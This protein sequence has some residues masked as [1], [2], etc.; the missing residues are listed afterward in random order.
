[1][2]GVLFRNFSYITLSQAANY[3]IPLITIPYISRVVGVEKF[4]W[5]EFSYSVVLYF[6]QLVE[7]SFDITA[8]RRMAVISHNPILVSRLFSTVF[9]SKM[10]LWALSTVI[11][12][13]LLATNT[14][15]RA[16]AWPLLGYYF[17]TFSF[18][19]SQNWFFQGLQKL[20]VVALANV[21]LKL[22]FAILLFL[23]VKAESDY[24]L[25]AVSTTVGYLLV[26]MVTFWYA[27]RLIPELRVYFPGFK[28][29]IRNIKNGFYIFSAGMAN[30]F[31]A[32]SGMYWAGTL[33]GTAQ[34]GHFSAAHKLYM[35][36]QSMM[37]Y[38][39][40]MTLL[41]HLS[42]KMMEGF[43]VY[44]KTFFRYLKWILLSTSLVS[45]LLYLMS[46][47]V[48][49]VLFGKDFLHAHTLFDLFIPSLI[50][51]VF[52]NLIVYQ[53]FIHLKRDDLHFKVLVVLM[54]ISIT[55]NYIAI[56]HFGAIGGAGFRSIMDM[57]YVLL[58]WWWL[59][60]AFKQYLTKA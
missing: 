20:G 33:L 30:K 41:P 28:L 27:F 32:L 10:I 56:K 1:M 58:S 21:G 34:L 18:V 39:V 54:V 38:P 22:I 16:Y 48:F 31:Y 46:P 7:Y 24:Y 11:F 59:L 50:A 3:L 17:I 19:L 53:A 40:Q 14:I 42:K 37:F 15:F 9:W 47:F 57:L 2:S 49:K 26:S 52:I 55:G 43:E 5:L 6:I 36:V 23:F 45:V 25:V 44:K 12:G 13:L 29:I 60:R 8:T 4:G 35:V 51:G